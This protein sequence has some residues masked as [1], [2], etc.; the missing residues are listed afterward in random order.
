MSDPL[1]RRAADLRER[2]AR[3]TTPHEKI[4]IMCEMATVARMSMAEAASSLRDAAK[5]HASLCRAV[6]GRSRALVRHEGGDHQREYHTWLGEVGEE[7][8]AAE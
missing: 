1:D 2:L 4:D 3:A 5:H 7:V 6:C 8:R